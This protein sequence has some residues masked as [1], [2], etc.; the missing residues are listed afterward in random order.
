VVPNAVHGDFHSNARRD[1]FRQFGQD[2]EQKRFPSP[3]SAAKY[4]QRCYYVATLLPSPTPFIP[5]SMN[6]AVGGV[7]RLWSRPFGISVGLAVGR[8]PY[9][10]RHWAWSGREG[11]VG[12]GLVEMEPWGFSFHFH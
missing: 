11:S 6:M 7:G 4:C 12:L 2:R 10:C 9:R 3:V 5:I 8:V 1:T